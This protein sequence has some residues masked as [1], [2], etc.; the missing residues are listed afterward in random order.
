MSGETSRHIRL[1]E[2]LIDLVE[3]QHRRCKDS[4][5]LADH[6]SFGANRPPMLGG[7][8]P[9]LYAHDLPISSRIVGEAKTEHDLTTDRSARQLQAFLDHLALYTQSTMYVAV[10]WTAAPR[11][12][13]LLNSLREPQHYAICLKV[14]PV[15]IR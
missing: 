10:P 8:T 3:L 4:I 1:V 15:N 12:R 11:A 14:I 6:R 2:A 7:F 5:V 13:S 9:D